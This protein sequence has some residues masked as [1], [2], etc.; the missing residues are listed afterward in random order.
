M[1]VFVALRNVS[2]RL[3]TRVVVRTFVF[4]VGFELALGTIW[5]SA[6]ETAEG[7]ATSGGRGQC[8]RLGN[9]LAG[10]PSKSG[11]LQL[12]ELRDLPSK[13]GFG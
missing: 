13:L 10:A 4:Q 5:S 8:R 6:A 12:A 1:F 9:D 7:W 11:L 3:V 2:C